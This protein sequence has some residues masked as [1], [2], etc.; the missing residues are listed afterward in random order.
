MIRLIFSIVFLVILA[1][2][3]AF[4]A[5]FSTDVNLFGYKLI[6]VPTVAVVLLTLVTGVIYS[7][8]LYII[9]Y[10]VKRRAEKAK[11]LKRKNSDKAKEL[12]TQEQELKNAKTT[13]PPPETSPA[14]VVPAD[15]PNENKDQKKKRK[16]KLFGGSSKRR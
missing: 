16:L 10:F 5:Q 9:A 11:D 15:V 1:V 2:F 6:A 14:T 7:F 13:L 4:N 12:K 3:I 8:G